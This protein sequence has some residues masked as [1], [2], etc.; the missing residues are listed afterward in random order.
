MKYKLG[1]IGAGNMAEAICRSVVDS[2][3]FHTEAICAY[4]LVPQRC[5]YFENEFS[6][7]ICRNNASLVENTE[8]IIL[9]I[10]PQQMAD[11]LGQI[12]SIVRTSQLLISIAAG[13]STRFL[14]TALGKSV[15]VII[16]TNLSDGDRAKLVEEIGVKDYLIKAD[17]DLH[18]VV[19]KVKEKLA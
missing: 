11:V 13:I 14:E 2:G 9:A 16:L 1:F 4:D 5:M 8:S 12:R 3:L 7:Q 18:E 17:W 6:V 10:K 19:T 15:P